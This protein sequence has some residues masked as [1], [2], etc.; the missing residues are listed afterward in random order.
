MLVHVLLRYRWKYYI[1]PALR[2]HYG[3]LKRFNIVMD[4]CTKMNN[5][6]VNGRVS[7]QGR[8]D[9]K[10]PNQTNKT[11]AGAAAS[12]RVRS[13]CQVFEGFGK[14]HTRFKVSERVS[15]R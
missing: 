14:F 3:N 5:P 13:V 6:A 4:Q 7:V 2:R 8:F 15:L 10:Q 12:A 9:T 11:S 1:I